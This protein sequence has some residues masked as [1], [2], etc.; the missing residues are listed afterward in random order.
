MICLK[1]F[2]RNCYK[3]VRGIIKSQ[4]IENRKTT[5]YFEEHFCEG[6]LRQII[7]LKKNLAVMQQGAH[8]SCVVSLYKVLSSE[9]IFLYINTLARFINM[10]RLHIID[11]IHSFTYLFKRGGC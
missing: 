10:K 2:Q 6:H 4:F 11:V 8:R 9:K 1:L 3:F 7:P 5:L